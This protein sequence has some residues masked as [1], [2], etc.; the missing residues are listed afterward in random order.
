MNDGLGDYGDNVGAQQ[1]YWR[2]VNCRNQDEKRQ[3]YRLRVKASDQE[4]VVFRNPDG[5]TATYHVAAYGKWRSSRFAA[6]SSPQ[7]LN[8]ECGGSCAMSSAPSQSLVLVQGT[9]PPVLVGSRGNIGIKPSEPARF[10]LNDNRSGYG[11][12]EGEIE[13]ILQCVK[14][15]LAS[16]ALI[17]DPEED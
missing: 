15:N 2:C 4:G 13:I 8:N 12:N 11:D 14:C 7:G 16:H 17:L 3:T 6:F 9:Y 5:I 10:T 1:V